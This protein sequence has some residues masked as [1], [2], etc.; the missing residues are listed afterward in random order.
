M[1]VELVMEE[2][3]AAEGHSMNRTSPVIELYS[4]RKSAENSSEVFQ[5]VWKS[6]ESFPLKCSWTNYRRRFHT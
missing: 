4:S 6:L 3:R 1:K 2:Q 5:A